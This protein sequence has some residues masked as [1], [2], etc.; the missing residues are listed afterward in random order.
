MEKKSFN[1]GWRFETKGKD[2]I[3]LTLPHDAQ[4]L[5]GRAFDAEGGSGHGYF[6]SNVYTYEKSFHAPTLWKEKE[7]R[8]LFEGVYRNCIVEVNGKKAGEHK[9]G[10]TQFCVLLDDYLNYE[11]ENTVK[12]TVDN[13]KL[14]NSR[15]YTGGGIY[16]P[17]SLVIG[18]KNGISFQGVKITTLEYQPAQILVETTVTDGEVVVEILK[19]EQKVAEGKGTAVKIDIPNAKLWSEQHPELYQAHV[20]VYRDGVL[21]DE[22]VENF[23][24]RKLT[25]DTTGFY[26]NGESTLLR[27]GCVH[28]DNG[29]VGAASLRESE[30]RRVRI[31]KEQGFNAIRVSHNPASS[32]MLDACDY[33]GMYVMDEAFD[34]WYIRKNKYD[35]GVDFMDCWKDDISAMVTRDYNHPSVVMYSIGNEVSEPGK[36]EGVKQG[37]EIISLIKSIDDTRAVTGGMNLMIM[38]NYAKGKGLYDDVDKGVMANGQKEEDGSK[39]GSL[40]FNTIVSF[41]GPG[42]NKAGNSKKVDQVTT[43]I[44]DALDIAGY[45]YASGRYPL[46]G[47]KHPNRIVVGSET[48]PYEIAKNWKMVETYP[49]LIGDFMWTAWDYLGEAGLGAWS[50]T[51]GVPFNRP[52]PWLLAGAGVIDILGN[53]DASAGL[54]KVVWK[55]TKHP[56]IGVR[57]VNHPKVRV[58]KSMWRGTNAI[59]SWSWKNCDGNKA[60]ID[61]FSQGDKVEL[62]VNHK[63]VGIKK[64]KEYHALFKTKYEPGEIEAVSYDVFGKE[65]GRSSLKSAGES[66]IS[67]EPEKENFK[68]DEIAY[69][70]ISLRDRDGIVESNADRTLEVSV[71]GGELLGFG[72]A[73]PCT[74]DDYTTGRFS[75]YY[76]RAQ[77]VVRVNAESNVTVKVQDNGNEIVCTL[78]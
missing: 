19:D 53:P 33:Y 10:Y 24:I 12:V 61:I 54:A 52:Y 26:V 59:E 3:V 15:W 64:L 69:I 68:K 36:E 14:P 4:L 34:M 74:K 50:Y 56:I 75:T 7:I 17:V 27:G 49:Y 21:V 63:S 31:L 11:E 20:M 25:W 65:L 23:G 62:F 2:P 13:S 45:N 51:G 48:F 72:S 43:P 78:N 18:E 5:D 16:R 73:N 6:L 35:Y 47:K 37:K 66:M 1:E 57:P 30:W 44:L 9:Y 67:I 55:T 77:A 39:N 71:E 42:M 28:H 29:I 41:I 8:L 76:G 46:E 22:C 40:L 60:E 38:G 32:S 70:D 58:S